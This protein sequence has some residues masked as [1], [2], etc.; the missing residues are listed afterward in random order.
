MD[1]FAGALT[2]TAQLAEFY[3]PAEPRAYRKVL[4]EIDEMARRL[5]AATPL[6][7]VGT[8]DARGRCD[9]S[10][11]GGQPG[12]V[13]V[14]DDHHV[15]IPDATGNRR[16][17]SLRNVV[18]T[19]EAGVL[20]VIP[21]RDMTLRLNGPARVTGAP[22]VLDRLTPVGKP[23]KTAIVV[24]AAE[25]YTHCPKAFIR[26]GTWDPSTW[27]AATDLPTPAEVTLA[28]QRDPDLTLAEVEHRQAESLKHRLA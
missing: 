25:L 20:F 12:F 11:R 7:L 8:H 23:P 19:G 14:L 13:S 2:E 26:S 3:E 16:L 18:D 6:V 22:E 27:P 21:G 10:P 28:H 9:V 1:P 4:A 5:I 24:R 15:A 17:D